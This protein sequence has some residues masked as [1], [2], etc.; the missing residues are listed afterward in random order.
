[1]PVSEILVLGGFLFIYSLEEFTHMILVC[2]GGLS[3]GHGHSHEE[4]EVPVEE[5]IQVGGTL[6]VLCVHTLHPHR[7]VQ[8]TFTALYIFYFFVCPFHLFYFI[9]CIIGGRLTMI[10]MT[11]SLGHFSRISHRVRSLYPRLLRGH[12]AGRQRE[13]DR[14]LLP[15]GCLRL[16][17]VGHL[18]H[19]GAQLGQICCTYRDI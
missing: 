6:R 2:T 10:I 17:Q 7:N 19:G 9:D 4:I 1:M 12:R 15:A 8:S 5:S 13:S 18:R 11:I 3:A 14:H 16:P